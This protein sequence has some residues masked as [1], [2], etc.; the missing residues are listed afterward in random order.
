MYLIYYY[1]ALEIFQKKL[2]IHEP[3][4]VPGIL[5]IEV[6][7]TANCAGKGCLAA[8]S[9]AQNSSHREDAQHVPY[10]LD[11]PGSFDHDG[12]LHN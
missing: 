2:R 1:Q 9:R 6:M 10:Y 5:Q 4:F 7:V 11:V 3:C 8:L 12:F